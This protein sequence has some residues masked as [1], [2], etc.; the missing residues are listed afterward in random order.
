[1]AF[2]TYSHIKITGISACVPKQ[3]VDNELIYSK[4]GGMTTSFYPQE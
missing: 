4:W 1:M 2:S 3:V